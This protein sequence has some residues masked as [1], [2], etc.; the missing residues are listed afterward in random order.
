MAG[1]IPNLAGGSEL[2]G[3]RE[4]SGGRE[5]SG[6]SEAREQREVLRLIGAQRVAPRDMGM[7]VG[8][9]PG[10]QRRGNDQPLETALPLEIA[11][12]V[13]AVETVDDGLG[14][15][16]DGRGHAA[17]RGGHVL[18]QFESTLAPR[19]SIVRKGHDPDLSGGARG[20]AGGAV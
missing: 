10:A 3:N 6:G 17:E 19:P 4:W 2:P 14:V 16:T 7:A 13:K 9:Q 5:L 8:T 20:G 12:R 1:S 18:Q 15:G 11:R